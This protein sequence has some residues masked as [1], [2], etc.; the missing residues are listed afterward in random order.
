MKI[1]AVI[2]AAGLSSRMKNFKPMLELGGSTIIKETIS[3]LRKAGVDDIVV[4]VG[5][6]GKELARHLSTERI[7]IVENPDYANGE[8]FDSVRIGLS[9]LKEADILLLSPADIPM[10]SPETAR[11]LCAEMARTECAVASPMYEGQKGHP[12]AINREVVGKILQYTGED[13]L[14]GALREFDDNHRLVEVE[15]IGILLDADMPEDYERL[16]AYAVATACR[17]DV[18]VRTNIE[19]VREVPFWNAEL[20]LLLEGVRQVGSIN[21]SCQE[22]GISYSKGWNLIKQAEYRLGYPLL[23]TNTGGVDG[24]GSALTEEA[25]ILM[26]AYN[27]MIGELDQVAHQLFRKHFRGLF[28]QGDLL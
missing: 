14:R 21:R 27:A 2:V 12:V 6:K 9:H 5:Y 4:V 3:S 1:G 13:G 7:T 26:E 18:S 23:S 11:I 15:D 17:G 10:F 16:R 24:G 22:V 8:M 19:L 28:Q 20:A 25:R